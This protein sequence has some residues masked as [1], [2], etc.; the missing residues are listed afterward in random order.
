M[1][2]VVVGGFPP[3]ARRPR[4]SPC[5]NQ[6]LPPRAVLPAPSPA[7]LFLLAWPSPSRQRLG[8]A[9]PEDPRGIVVSAPSCVLIEGVSAS[10]ALGP[11]R[12]QLPQD[13]HCVSH[14]P[15]RVEHRTRAGAAQ[16][17]PS[18]FLVPGL[19]L[20]FWPGSLCRQ[21]GRR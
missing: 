3:C 16:A 21:P 6:P 17:R 5:V 2:V 11:T 14:A 20:T 7:A 19:P 12:I 1:T 18:N 8:E 4:Q 10:L 9:R 13:R 15:W